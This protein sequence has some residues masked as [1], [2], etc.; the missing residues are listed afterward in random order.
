[1]KLPTHVVQ[2]QINH[3]GVHER[4]PRAAGNWRQIGGS[5][6]DYQDFFGRWPHGNPGCD[7]A[8]APPGRIFIHRHAWGERPQLPP[9][10]QQQSPASVLGKSQAEGPHASIDV[11][12]RSCQRVPRELWPVAQSGLIKK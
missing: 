8:A 4:P 1:M 5:A 2:V 10:G 9:T 7:M 6:R 3:S 12:E 11:S